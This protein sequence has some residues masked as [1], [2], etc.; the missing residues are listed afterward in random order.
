VIGQRCDH[1]M[2]TA[3]ENRLWPTGYN[4][5]DAREVCR[6]REPNGCDE[7]GHSRRWPACR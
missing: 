4:L 1:A 2:I 7:V 6:R 3:L 5:C